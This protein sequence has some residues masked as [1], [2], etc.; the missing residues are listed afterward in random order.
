MSEPALKL[1]PWD[2]SL[3]DTFALEQVVNTTIDAAITITGT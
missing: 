2:S 3:P 1:R